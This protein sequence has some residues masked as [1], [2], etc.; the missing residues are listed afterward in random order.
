M[1]AAVDVSRNTIERGVR[2]GLRPELM[3]WQSGIQKSNYTIHLEAATVVGRT[4][5]FNLKDSA[6]TMSQR[7]TEQT[8]AKEVLIAI[9]FGKS[10][11]FR[12]YLRF[13]HIIIY[14]TVIAAVAVAG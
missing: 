13:Q 12:D 14:L 4:K 3:K 9:R 11:T 8:Q 7:Q 5:G 2:D 6:I 1:A 10:L